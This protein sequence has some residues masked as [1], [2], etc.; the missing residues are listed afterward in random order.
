MAKNTMGWSTYLNA[1]QIDYDTFTAELDAIVELREGPGRGAG[2]RDRL[3]YPPDP[4][5]E[6]G[7]SSPSSSRARAASQ[8]A[9]TPSS[10]GIALL[11]ASGS[12][13]R[14]SSAMR[15]AATRAPSSSTGPG[16]RVDVRAGPVDLHRA[17][18][19]PTG[20]PGPDDPEGNGGGVGGTRIRLA[21]GGS[22]R[23][24]W[25]GGPRVRLQ[26][27]A[28]SGRIARIAWSSSGLALGETT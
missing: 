20:L 11:G 24:R 4:E 27:R 28:R 16:E 13:R 22:G 8:S 25:S 6:G 12:A 10:R 5:G 14:M 19:Y 3:A 18:R 7:D 9:R 1:L 26:A 2:R 23:R 21:N 17:G 15:A